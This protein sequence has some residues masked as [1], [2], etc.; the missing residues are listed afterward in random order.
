MPRDLPDWGAQSSQATV[1]EVTDLGELAVRLGSIVTHDRRGD[2]IWFDGFEDGLLKWTTATFGTGAAVDLSV[3]RARNGLFAARLVA[4]SDG[5]QA[6]RL[7][8]TIPFPVVSPMGA[9]FSFMLQQNIDNL[10]FVFDLFDGVDVTQYLITWS[11]V[12]N[13]LL[14]QD[15]AG[16]NQVLASTIDL[17]QVVSLFHTIKLVVDME[18]S[19][20]GRL[21]L[22]QT[23]YSLSDIAGF[24]SADVT[25]P[26]V[27]IRI[28]LIGRADSNDIIRV[29]DV[30]LTQNE[31]V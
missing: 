23:S 26:A 2:V 20:Y 9:E 25:S 19:E 1:H 6:A 17:S 22:D 10:Q 13:N 21:I 11:D 8:K 15:S 4:G 28:N 12:N 29:D 14:Y 3:V 18:S 7:D 31:N 16:D 27:R 5:G 24:V 30:I